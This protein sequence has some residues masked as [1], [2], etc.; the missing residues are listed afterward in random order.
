MSIVFFKKTKEISGRFAGDVFPGPKRAVFPNRVFSQTVCFPKPC[1][2]PNRVFCRGVLL[3]TRI[4]R[5]EDEIAISDS[6]HR[7][8]GRTVFVIRVATVHRRA[9]QP[10]P[11]SS[12][13]PGDLSTVSSAG[14]TK[15]VCSVST[16]RPFRPLGAGNGRKPSP[17]DRAI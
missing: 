10:P 12:I 16:H 6:V 1:V 8:E 9:V 14:I 7:P 17:L 15:A 2:F 5:S 11:L 4:F 13:L 3:K